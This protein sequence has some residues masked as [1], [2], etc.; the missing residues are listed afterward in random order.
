MEAL[1]VL[2]VDGDSKCLQETVGMLSA[3]ERLQIVETARSG[4]EAV[5]RAYS[6]CPQVVVME[7]SMETPRAGLLALKEICASVKNCRVVFYSAVQD[8]SVI[9]QAYAAGADNYLFKPSTAPALTR[10]IVAA[11]MN[12][13][14]ISADSSE[15][16]LQDYRQLRRQQESLSSITRIVLKLTSTELSILRLL[17]NGMQPAEIESI[18][19]IEH[20]TMKTHLS[21]I[22][23]KFDMDSLAQ[24]VEALQACDFFGFIDENR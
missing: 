15:T 11:G 16:L 8:P 12:R 5:A 18:R 9:L 19:F 14:F 13:T 1:Q 21:H 22:I 17:T 3:R 24:V 4:Y 10:A 6:C 23:R 20:S 2:I 7:M